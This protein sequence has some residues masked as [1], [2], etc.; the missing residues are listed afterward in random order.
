M[1][2]TAI[3]ILISVFFCVSLQGIDTSSKSRLF[4]NQSEVNTALSPN[5]TI[6]FHRI[7]CSLSDKDTHENKRNLEL[8]HKVSKIDG[9]HVVLTD[10]SRLQIGWWY[11]G[12]IKAWKNGDRLK[13]FFHVNSSNYLE[14]QN[15]DTTGTAWGVFQN[16]PSPNL[17]ERI[18]RISTLES[19]DSSELELNSGKI[20]T[21]PGKDT[22]KNS[23]WNLGNAIFIFHESQNYCLY[24][25]DKNEYFTD[26]TLTSCNNESEESIDP[27]N[28]EILML[29]ENINQKVIAQQEASKQVSNAILS[30]YAGLKNP[31]QPIGV[32][33]FL[34]P[35]G[36][37]KT[38]FAKVLAEELY[39]NQK[40]LVRF[41]MSHF[42]DDFASVARLIG[43]PPGVVD[44]ERGGQ[45]SNELQK[46]PRCVVLLDEMEKAHPVVH[47]FFLPVF[48][49]GRFQDARGNLT[50]CNETIFIMTSN[51]CAMDIVNYYRQGYSQEN[52]LTIIEPSLMKAL[53][54]ELYNRVQPIVFAPLGIESM[55]A[56]VDLQF[57]Q[58]KKR[59][60]ETK[61]I[62]V[63]FDNSV[64]EYLIVNGY[65]PT[66][67]ARPLKKLIDAKIITFFS[68]AILRKQV[69]PNDSVLLTYVSED[70]A[71]HILK[72]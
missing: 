59:F 34:G 36:V 39:H 11:T 48:D 67:G 13:I 35:T 52:I 38:E 61:N 47:K 21:M 41:D 4:V 49:E 9:D 19:S 29:E 69:L 14:I 70:D 23:G 31:E 60:L 25:L 7:N 18:S 57:K 40:R 72:L 20:F 33:L 27:E 46:Q 58:L 37:G 45:L 2:L 51:L 1:K 12:V 42:N 10:G 55:G 28:S 43:W 17:T 56:L 5:E 71:W 62:S 68:H 30:F 32:F 50:L 15:I 3:S 26:V 63:S 65:H 66:L 8:F 24:N 44:S 6:E 16:I 53:S 64:R 54:P 22:F